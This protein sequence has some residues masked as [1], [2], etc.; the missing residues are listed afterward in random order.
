MA[1]LSM[2]KQAGHNV[3]VYSIQGGK[4]PI[5]DVSLG[6]DFRTED[7]DKFLADGVHLS[8]T[9]AKLH[10]GNPYQPCSSPINKKKLFQKSALPV[11]VSGWLCV[12]V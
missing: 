3:T 4:V 8:I 1:P 6:D 2:F 7:V 10:T 11:K 5:D 9:C 12:Q